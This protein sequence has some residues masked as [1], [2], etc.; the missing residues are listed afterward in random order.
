[1]SEKILCVDCPQ[2]RGCTTYKIMDNSLDPNKVHYKISLSLDFIF[3]AHKPDEFKA[4]FDES[5]LDIVENTAALS[6]FIKDTIESCECDVQALGARMDVNV[7]PN[8]QVFD[9]LAE[10]VKVTHATGNK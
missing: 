5:V 10:Y 7:I 8:K 3:T 6:D 9:E 4:D 2:N 1:M